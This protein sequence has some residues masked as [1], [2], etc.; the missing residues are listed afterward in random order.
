RRDFLK[1]AAG[2][3]ALSQQRILGANDT[4]RVGGIGVGLRCSSLLNMVKN[5]GGAAIVAVCDAYEP[6]RQAAVA[7]LAPQAREFTD[8]RELLAQKDI[9]AVVIG[10][11][12]HWHVPMTIDAVRAGKD[13]YV[14]KPVSHTIEEGERLVAAMSGSKQIVQVGYQQRS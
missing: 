2:L 8:Y 7:K 6:R 12:D 11:P 3:T 14:E 5:T 13:V 10:A 1:A 4:I 9:D